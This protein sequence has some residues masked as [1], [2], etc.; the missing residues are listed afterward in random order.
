M[1][2]NFSLKHPF[3]YMFKN[4]SKK[5]EVVSQIL[6]GEKFKILSKQKKWIKIK[7]SFDKYVGYIKNEY[8]SE[9]YNPT[10]KIF[11]LKSQIFKKLNN[12]FIAINKFLYF[13]SRI[14]LKTQNVNFI[15]FEKD[16]WIKKKDVKNI[17]HIE[18]DFIK[19]FKLFLKTK[20]LWGGKSC[21]GIDCSALIQM[22][23]YYNNLFFPRDTKDQI[24]YCR[25]ISKLSYKSGNI[26]FWKGHV[27]IC[28]KNNCFIHAYGPR[29]QVI[30]MKTDRTIKLIE[31]TAKLKIKKISNINNY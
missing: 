25:K 10:H 5:S 8:Y 6:Y 26:I 30:M 20:Y 14:T 12:K 11:K 24:R 16:K 13:G 9:Y 21:D 19:I 18:K 15:E 7:T 4:T 23:Y 29:K 3:V 1:S 28:L 27:G 2:K 22:Y 17:Y 31:E